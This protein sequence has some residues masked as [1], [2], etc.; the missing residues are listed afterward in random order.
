EST[1]AL[2]DGVTLKREASRLEGLTTP[3]ALYNGAALDDAL[4]LEVAANTDVAGT[5]QVIHY[6][7]GDQPAHCN[8]RLEVVLGTGSRMTLIE[9]YLGRGPVLTNAVTAI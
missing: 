3:F 7:D 6:A 9:Q 1:S 2:P 8:T 4:T 5:V